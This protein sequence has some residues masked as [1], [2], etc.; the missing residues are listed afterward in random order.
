VDSSDD[1]SEGGVIPHTKPDVVE[2][3]EESQDGE[4]ES[5]GDDPDEEGV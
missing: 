5:D 3:V 1:E 4:E 2:E